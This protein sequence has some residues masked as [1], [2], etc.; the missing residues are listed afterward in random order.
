[1]TFYQRLQKKK[2]KGVGS[3]ISN[4]K[5][6][7]FLVFNRYIHFRKGTFNL[8]YFIKVMIFK[9][10]RHITLSVQSSK[11]KCTELS[12]SVDFVLCS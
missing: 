12:T 2:K 1:M 7:E 6:S 3:I 8:R 9:I 10:E 5:Q 11:P 4:L